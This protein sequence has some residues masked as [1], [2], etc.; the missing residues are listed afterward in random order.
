LLAGP[1]PATG[2]IFSAIYWNEFHVAPHF[3]GH[4]AAA[5]QIVD[6]ALRIHADA[7]A[8]RFPRRGL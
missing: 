2:V 4:D 1:A 6:Q 7:P 8:F 5:L 3:Q